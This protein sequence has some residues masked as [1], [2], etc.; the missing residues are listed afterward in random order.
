MIYEKSL[1]L[2][3]ESLNSLTR[4]GIIAE[5]V[6]VNKST[7]LLGASSVLDSVAFV[8]FLTDI[9]DR[10]CRETGKELF[11]VLNDIHG[12]NPDSAVLSVDTLAQYLV[13]FANKQ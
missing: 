12:F 5:K 8:T 1:Q 2:I 4:S 9:E 6:E 3:Q 10:I 7:P 11:L 13:D